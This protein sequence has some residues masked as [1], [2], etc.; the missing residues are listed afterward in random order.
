MKRFLFTIA[1]LALAAGS[2][3][4]QFPGMAP[5]YGPQGYA[6]QGYGPQGGGVMPAGGFGP[7]VNPYGAHV[8]GG[9]GC[10][11]GN[12]G[13]GCSSDGSGSSRFGY[14]PIIKRLFNIKNDPGSCN[15]GNCGRGGYPGGA[16]A[17]PGG[18]LVFPNNP[19]IR[20]PRDFFEQ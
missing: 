1:C 16:V 2:A 9:G 14:N 20:S 3:S 12:C 13:S 5:G 17:G 18:T 10:A 4:A 6:P 19:Y 15:N 7:M 8:G 11:T